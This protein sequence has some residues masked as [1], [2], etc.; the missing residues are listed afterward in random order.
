MNNSFSTTRERRTGLQRGHLPFLERCRSLLVA[1]ALATGVALLVGS[2]PLLAQQAAA[3]AAQTVNINRADA[4]SLAAALKGIGHA[5]AVEIVRHRET[6]GPFASV[7]ELTEVK[8][9]GKSTLDM[10]R[11]LITLE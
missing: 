5:R 7:D 11:H 6:Y 8:G 2:G 10:N 4:T 1:L 3:T 9:I